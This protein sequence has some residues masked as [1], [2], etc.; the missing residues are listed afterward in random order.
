V[1]ISRTEER[2]LPR[3]SIE[4]AIF[5]WPGVVGNVDEM[6]FRPDS[7]TDF[8]GQLPHL[9]S[10][11]AAIEE[12]AAADREALGDERLAW[13][14]GLPRIQIQA[15][16]ALVH[17]SPGSLWRA[18]T[19]DATDADLE[20]VYSALGQP[21][22]VYAHIH[23]SFV[24][25]ISDMTVVNTGSVILSYD[26]DRRAA[27]LLLNGRDSEIRRVEYDVGKELKALA[28]SGLPHSDWT[29]KM[30]ESARP[31]SHRPLAVAQHLFYPF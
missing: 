5:G 9:Q 29:A 19:P 8:A 17:A 31:Q 2:I 13:L 20:S 27:Y 24:R 4:F 23:C 11:F 3:L 12:M 14:S 21:I 28:A 25:R 26:G 16:I 10:L 1:E 30:L 6:L 7:L 18:P 22:A 15:P